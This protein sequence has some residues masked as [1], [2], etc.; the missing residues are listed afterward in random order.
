MGSHPDHRGRYLAEILSQSDDWLEVTHDYIQWLFPNKR[1][2]GVL[3]NGPLLDKETVAFFCND[4]ILQDHLQASLSRLMQFYGLRLNDG[5][6]VKQ[7]NWV[8][9]KANWFLRDTHNNL[10]ITRIL[11]CLK[12]CGCTEKAKQIHAGLVQLRETEPDCGL[13]EKPFLFWQKAINA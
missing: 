2:S 10:R 11:L 4:D 1:F 12:A 6:L 3:P 8:D 7:S 5:C 9:R 13:S